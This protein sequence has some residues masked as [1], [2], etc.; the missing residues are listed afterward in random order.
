MQM[1][2]D[3][4]ISKAL[5]LIS[6]NSGPQLFPVLKDIFN[7]GIETEFIDKLRGYIMSC[8]VKSYSEQQEGINMMTQRTVEENNSKRDEASNKYEKLLNL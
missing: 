5:R 6:Q 3:V 2:K 1:D 7:L 8:D 4:I